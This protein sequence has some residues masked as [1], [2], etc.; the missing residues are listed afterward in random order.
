MRNDKKASSENYSFIK[1]TIKEQPTDRKRLAG[2]FLTAAVCGVIFG[3]CAAGTMALIVPKA[4]ERFGTAPDQKAVV[5]LTPSVKAEQVTPTPEATEQ[6]K[7]SAST[8]WQNDLSDGMSQIAEEP[9]R[10]LVR[11]SA[12][13]EDSDLLDDSFLEYGDEEGFVF[14]KNSEAFYILTVSDQMQEADKFTVTFSDG[15]VTDGIL[16][17]KDLRTGFFVIKVPFTSVDEETQEKIPAA[18]LVTADDMKQ[19]ESV[20]A[21]GSPSGDYDSLMGGTIT[22]V[23]GTLK[24]ADEEYGMLTTDMVGS[25]EGGGILLNSSGE[26]AGIIWNQEEDRTNVIRAVE[27][28]QLRPLLESMANGEDI[29]YIGIMGATISSYQSEN[30]DVP[31]GVY[32]DAVDEDSPAMTAGIQNGDILHALDGQEVQSME[33]YA[34]VLQGLNKGTRTTVNV[35][36][37]NPFG[38]YED[39]QLKV[40]I[41]E[42]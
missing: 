16:C 42:K 19:T 39:V 29:C 30:L 33:E 15:T 34:S 24:V 10:A 36:R 18:P 25:E 6:E 26:V 14:L 41:K 13:G 2:K 3:A 12:A 9:R 22:S 1:E 7:T 32:V 27:T 4:L 35:Y 21:I 37:K 11:I 8:A 20:I 17:K 31:R 40:T 23:T 28:A 38:E 5:T